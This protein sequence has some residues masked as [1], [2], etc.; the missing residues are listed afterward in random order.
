MKDKNENLLN[1][2]NNDIIVR[3]PVSTTNTQDD[4][5]NTHGEEDEANHCKSSNIALDTKEGNRSRS[6][7]EETS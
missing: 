2:I 4:R 7:H 3:G 5:S 6:N 1:G